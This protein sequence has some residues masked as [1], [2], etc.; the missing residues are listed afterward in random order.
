MKN[1][2]GLPLNT[3]VIAIIVVTV[4]VVLIMIFTGGIGG[5][6]TG[7]INCQTKAN[8]QCMPSCDSGWAQD[9]S[10]KCL[11]ADKKA[12][13]GIVCCVKTEETGSFATCKSVGGEM[14]GKDE[15]LKGGAITA[16]IDES[17]GLNEVC[18]SLNKLFTCSGTITS[19]A[20]ECV[21]QNADDSVSIAEL[22][23]GKTCC[24]ITPAQQ[25][26]A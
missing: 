1:A 13:P 7:L 25:A 23:N 4:L 5:I 18:C 19:S 16:S 26:A 17:P 10:Y 20:A 22:E 15:C 8:H 12:I 3:I 9:P 2:Q 14:V 6:T 21:P 11:D 24:V